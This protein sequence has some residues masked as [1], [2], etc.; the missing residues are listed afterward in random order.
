MSEE[1]R[2][3]APTLIAAGEKQL[4]AM[5]TPAFRALLTFDP[6]PALAKVKCPVLAVFGERDSQVPPPLNLPPMAGALESSGNRDYSIVK[7]PA[8]NHLFQTSKTGL[9]TEYAAIDETFAPVALEVISSWIVRH[10]R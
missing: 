2:A 5:M 3:A 6:A 1:D 9:L 4:P 10:T 8:L 7:L